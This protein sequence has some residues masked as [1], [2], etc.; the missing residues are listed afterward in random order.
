MSSEEV[1]AGSSA[2]LARGRPHLPE[3]RMGLFL[4]NLPGKCPDPSC[5]LGL[6]IAEGNAAALVVLL[7]AAGL[8]STHGSDL[9][10]PGLV[11]SRGSRGVDRVADRHV[12]NPVGGSCHQ[13]GEQDGRAVDELGELVDLGHHA[14]LQEVLDP[15]WGVL[16][17]SLQLDLEDCMREVGVLRGLNGDA[18]IPPPTLRDGRCVSTA[19]LPYHG[20][21]GVQGDA[22]CRIERNLERRSHVLRADGRAKLLRLDDPGDLGEQLASLLDIRVLLAL[23]LHVVCELV[24]GVAAIQKRND[25]WLVEDEALFHRHIPSPGVQVSLPLHKD[26]LDLSSIPSKAKGNGSWSLVH[27]SVIQLHLAV[28]KVDRV[29]KLR[30]PATS[31]NTED[32]KMLQNQVLQGRNVLRRYPVLLRVTNKV[33][34]C[35]VVGSSRIVLTQKRMAIRQC[36]KDIREVVTDP[37]LVPQFGHI[38]LMARGVRHQSVVILEEFLKRLVVQVDK[39]FQGKEV[40]TQLLCFCLQGTQLREH[41][42]RTGARLL[43]TLVLHFLAPLLTAVPQR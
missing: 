4:R 16:H 23:P 7:L 25:E 21:V 2:L 33:L 37:I 20:K 14:R 36:H 26:T 10:G 35:I 32:R 5:A 28:V 17:V 42:S 9:G 27:S 12:I 8:T 22:N 3:K 1:S 39:F 41:G 18:F 30:V 11:G 31:P 40:G 38:E 13:L 43:S 19:V 24:H 29:D 34:L 15:A 6:S